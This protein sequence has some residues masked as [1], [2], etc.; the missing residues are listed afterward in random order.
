MT[1]IFQFMQGTSTLIFLLCV[2]SLTIA[3][4]EVEYNFDCLCSKVQYFQL[5]GKSKIAQTTF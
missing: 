3:Y 4:G 5:T 1:N 2:D